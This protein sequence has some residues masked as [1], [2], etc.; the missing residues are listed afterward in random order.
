MKNNV[1]NMGSALSYMTECTLATVCGIASK[2]FRPKHEFQRQI[3]MA[4][5]GID[6]IKEFGVEYGDGGRVEQI[7]KIGWSVAQWAEQFYPKSILRKPMVF[8]DG[9][10]T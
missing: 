1:K 7:I 2:R 6:W 10:R 5:L 4:Q 9:D 3:N 8:K